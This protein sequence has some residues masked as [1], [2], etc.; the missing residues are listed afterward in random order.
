MNTTD[1]VQS[2]VLHIEKVKAISYYNKANSQEK[3]FMEN[4]FGK[5]KLAPT[6]ICELITGWADII[7]LSGRD[8]KEFEL[9]PGEED[10]E[11]AYREAKLL[12]LVYNGG[13]MLD[14]MD[15]SQ[16]KHF[17]IHRIDPNSGFGLS[18]DVCVLWD[19]AAFA[20]VGVRLCFFEPK[21]AIDSGKKFPSIYS[22]L[23]IK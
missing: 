19:S 15:T 5:D 23:K 21:N 11:L 4:L 14:A 18:Y 6:D 7:S 8:P 1:T 17:P 10:D 9:R 2:R 12:A 3:T 16:Y 22:R 20:F 13:K